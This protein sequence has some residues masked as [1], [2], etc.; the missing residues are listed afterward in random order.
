MR[1]WHVR[2]AS[3]GQGRSAGEQEHNQGHGFPGSKEGESS[4]EIGSIQ[5]RPRLQENEDRGG[6]GVRGLTPSLSPGM[7]SFAQ[8]SLR[9]L[10]TGPC[11]V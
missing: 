9:A 8:R 7:F 1:C 3:E 2:K 6:G 4:R 10:A 11:T 5:W